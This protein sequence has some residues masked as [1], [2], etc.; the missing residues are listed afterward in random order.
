MCGHM[1]TLVPWEMWRHRKLFIIKLPN[2]TFPLIDR[3]TS[4][5]NIWL[6]RI[7]GL[8]WFVIK[9]TVHENIFFLQ[10]GRF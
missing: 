7:D 9:C 6:F 3:E 4:V 1:F 2:I 10:I 5:C 8:K